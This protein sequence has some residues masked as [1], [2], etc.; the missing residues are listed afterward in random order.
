MACNINRNDK[1]IVTGVTTDSG[2]ESVLFTQ[3]SNLVDNKP[4]TAVTLY[5]ATDTE[6]FKTFFQD[7]RFVNSLGE[8]AL[9]GEFY[10]NNEGRTWW[11][12]ARNSQEALDKFA[13][14]LDRIS[15]LTIGQVD[16]IVNFFHGMLINNIND[17][18]NISDI[19]VRKLRPILLQLENIVRKDPHRNN[20]VKI[21]KED[22]LNYDLLNDKGYPGISQSSKLVAAIK[23]RLAAEGIIEQQE[24]MKEEEKTSGLNLKSKELFSPK[25]NAQASTKL[26]FRGL[27][28]TFYTGEVIDG[29][30]KRSI[31]KDKTLGMPKFVNFS[32]VYNL[33]AQELT[34]IVSDKNTEDVY[35]AYLS[36]IRSLTK[37]YPFLVELEYKLENAK[38]N[39]PTSEQRRTRFTTAFALEQQPYSQTLYSGEAGSRTFKVGK[40]DVQAKE[41]V[42]REKWQEGFKNILT[43]YSRTG[44]HLFKDEVAVAAARSFQKLLKEYRQAAKA[45]KT[46]YPAQYIQQLSQILDSVGIDMSTEALKYHID[47]VAKGKTMASKV[48]DTFSNLEFVFG[49][50]GLLKLA[51]RYGKYKDAKRAQRPIED[52]NGKVINLYKDEKGVLA[53]AKSQAKFELGFHE[54]S[55]LGPKGDIYWPFSDISYL[56][57]IIAQF[58]QGD[59][60][61]LEAL[62]GQVYNKNSKWLNYLLADEKNREL[63]NKEVFMQMKEEDTYEGIKY[64]NLSEPDQLAD[65][66]NRVLKGHQF[67]MTPGNAR[68]LY[69]IVGTPQYSS[70]VNISLKNEEF[71]FEYTSDEVL[72]TFKNY[73]I[74]ELSA[75]EVAYNQVFDNENKLSKNKQILFY[76]Y[77]K[78][79]N[80]RVDGIPAGNAFKHYLFPELNFGSPIAAALKLYD[81]NGKPQ[82]INSETLNSPIIENLIKA[83]FELRAKEQLIEAIDYN[84]V[85]VVTSKKDKESVF[86][87]KQIDIN[88]LES[89]ELYKNVPDNLKVGRAISDYVYNSL[90]A[91]IE[92]T[93]LFVGNIAFYKSVEDFPKRSNLYSTGVT[94]LRI[95]KDK[96]TNLYEVNPFYLQSTVFDVLKPSDYI[97]DVESYDE[98]DLAD[99]TTWIT[100]TLRKQRMKGLGQWSAKTEA[101]FNRLMAGE[102]NTEDVLMLMPQ[103][104]TARGT[105][106]KNSLNVPYREKT[107][108]VTLWPGLVNTIQLQDLY[109]KMTEAETTWAEEHNGQEIGMSVSVE[110]AVKVGAGER[111]KIDDDAG[112]VLNPEEFELEYV[113]KSHQLY[114]KQQDVN[115]KGV[116]DGTFGS[117][118]KM[119]MLGDISDTAKIGSKSGPQWLQEVQDLESAISELGKKEFFD[120]FGISEDL[121]INEDKFR[122]EL[123]GIFEKDKFKDEA[124]LQGLQAGLEFDAIFQSRRKIMNKLANTLSKSTVTYSA[125]GTQAV[126][127]SSFGFLQ[128]PQSIAELDG[129][130]KSKIRWI[131]DDN[132]PLAPPRI[133]NGKLE[134]AQILLPYRVVENIPGWETMTN[135]ELKAAIGKDVLSVIGYRIPTQSLASIDAL[136]IVGILPAELGDT[137]VVYEDITRKTGSDF[138][139]DKL[140]MLIPHVFYSKKT[141][142][143]ELVDPSG[144]SRKSLENKRILLYKELFQSVS[145]YPRIIKSIDTKDLKEDA[146]YIEQLAGEQDRFDGLKLFSGQFQQELKRRFALGAIGVG[147][148]A[149]SIIDN[150]SSQIGKLNVSNIGI[151]ATETLADGSIVTSL[152]ETSRTDGLLVSEIQSGYMNAFVDIEKDPYIAML[153]VN[154]ETLNITTL[155]VR[156]QVP[157]KWINRF[158]KQPVIVDYVRQISIDKSPL[159]DRKVN[160]GKLIES[161]ISEYSTEN[162]SELEAGLSLE[163]PL[164]NVKNILTVSNLEQGISKENLDYQAAV[165]A[166]FDSI[167]KTADK[168]FDQN[169]ASKV[170]TKGVGQGMIEAR[171]AL[172]TKEEIETSDDYIEIGNFNEKFAEGTILGK[173]FENGPKL[174]IELFADKFLSGRLESTELAMLDATN[175]KNSKDYRLRRAME[176]R[177][178]SYMYSN[179][180]VGTPELGSPE[181]L[182]FDSATN[183]SLVQELRKMAIKYPDNILIGKDRGIL[184]TTLNR[185][186]EGVNMVPS[187]ISMSNAKFLPADIKKLARQAWE[188]GL[189]SSIE[190]EQIFYN[191]LVKYAYLT[192]GFRNGLKTFYDI[193]P[194]LWNVENK[195]NNSVQALG[196]EQGSML[197]AGIDQVIRHEYKNPKYAPRIR[198][199]KAVV[200]IDK[201]TGL[202]GGIKLLGNEAKRHLLTKFITWS[203]KGE[204]KLFK[205]GGYEI[206]EKG[207]EQYLN[208]L[209]YPVSP[210]G[211]QSEGGFRVVEYRFDKAEP[212]SM[213]EQNKVEVSKAVQ[214]RINK[215]YEMESARERV[216]EFTKPECI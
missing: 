94:P 12:K 127:I 82:P 76:H 23:N 138:D 153:N 179:H 33:L 195:F 154:A 35:E 130:A 55:V 89:G 123:I 212:E 171:M 131:K 143:L 72:N 3:L 210:L 183:K 30:K 197:Q 175:N 141:G 149:N 97:S 190:E 52:K 36:K 67:L 74:D 18:E 180:F 173:Y 80:E 7:S 137:A 155:L 204:A 164:D 200:P 86:T 50:Q 10:M 124:V 126:Q 158:L 152:H 29:V 121:E 174:F 77:D 168:I 199:S 205:N 194:I 39:S 59:L 13:F 65:R 109:D 206:V 34:G 85:G 32:E 27:H 71:T 157:T 60:S 81:Q 207:G 38:G 83:Q 19:D 118:T 44:K 198:K 129:E 163:N 106:I 91:N 182:L 146:T 144:S 119:L 110:S 42:V 192:S 178:Y 170:H 113:E 95:Y 213:F 37:Y 79:G 115:A 147:S 209:F 203:Y 100:P 17:I 45:D 40:A 169:L 51:D 103:K 196:L 177:M 5:A 90:I 125:N 208:P 62:K 172:Q 145:E 20:I 88:V 63:F 96:Q 75:M 114:G 193:V 166:Y 56:S 108:E 41:E 98:I 148:I 61:Y 142:K 102:L 112:A 31:R 201:A 73:I 189:N 26:L 132:T 165:I 181:Q 214:A 64:F 53:L 66:I 167:R 117:Q 156:A 14:G 101:S 1:G 104:S 162:S 84:L 24:E 105:E 21:L 57:Q 25:D 116:K 191:K 69:N 176:D 87:N 160:R 216:Q 139:I 22:L 128:N 215:A 47:E 187:E 133:V 11:A 93:K 99:A 159:L 6:D 122:K 8:P 46:A 58:K 49:K 184:K 28:D 136:D 54:N 151:G 68:T 202:F 48:L 16:D 186:E 185:N 107:A 120:R 92:S 111:T 188:D 2:E 4:E 9:V 161:L 70:G 135:A 211:Y 134:L 140:F 78:N 150:V 15:G 43:K